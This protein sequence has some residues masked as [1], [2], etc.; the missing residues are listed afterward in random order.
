M[1]IQG[2]F[3]L[4]SVSLTTVS[5]TAAPATEAPKASQLQ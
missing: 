2:T 3:W 5:A 4:A 1:E